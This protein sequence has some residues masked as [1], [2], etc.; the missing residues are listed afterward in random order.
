MVDIC[1][2]KGFSVQL[3]EAE[4]LPFNNEEF[5]VVSAIGLIE[6]LKED[7]KFLQEVSRVLKPNGKLVLEMRNELFKHWSGR[8]YQPERRSHNPE[9]LKLNGF[10]IKKIKYY[11]PHYFPPKFWYNKKY[12]CSAFVVEAEKI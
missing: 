12:I 9:N 11:H 3:S 2:E 1:K 10:K 4:I 7:D 8:V 6:Y 5:N